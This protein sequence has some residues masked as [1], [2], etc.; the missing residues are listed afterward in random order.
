MDTRS[1]RSS[2]IDA[3]IIP[4]P[5][6]G[7]IRIEKTY[8]CVHWAWLALIIAHHKP[9]AVTVTVS[10]SITKSTYRVYT[11]GKIRH[12]NI[13][14]HHIEITMFTCKNGGPIG[15][16]NLQC[17]KKCKYPEPIWTNGAINILIE[18]DII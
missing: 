2:G 17:F 9:K 8:T 4:S 15:M 6:D 10:N 11:E 12:H 1:S 18:A 14:G 3:R 5:T 13:N 7:T 16:E